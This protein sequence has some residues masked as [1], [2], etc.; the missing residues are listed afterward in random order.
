MNSNKIDPFQEFY[1]KM[2]AD[3]AGWLDNEQK[4]QELLQ[5]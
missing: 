2:N 1:K 5:D 3:L 4:I